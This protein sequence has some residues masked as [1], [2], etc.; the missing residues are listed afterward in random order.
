M[1]THELLDQIAE[2]QR[3]AEIADVPAVRSVCQDYSLAALVCLQHLRD[4]YHHRRLCGDDD[5]LM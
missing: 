2:W 5:I 1:E 3:L 4:E